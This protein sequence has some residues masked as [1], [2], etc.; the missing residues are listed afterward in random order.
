MVP[1]SLSL[2]YF[3]PFYV[4]IVYLIV[5]DYMLCRPGMNRCDVSEE[6][7][8]NA[9]H[10]LYLAPAPENGAS[11]DGRDVAAPGASLASGVCLGQN[12][13]LHVQNVPI[14][15]KKKSA[16]KDASSIPT[17]S[18][19]SQIPNFVKKDEQAFVKSRSSNDT[20]QY[21]HS[22][23]DSSSK[24]GLG[25]TSRL[26]DFGVEKHKPKQKDKHKNRRGNSDGGTILL[27]ILF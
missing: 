18:T 4:F 17:H 21:L 1:F 24:G 16:L 8:T 5:Y 25:N 15:E 23:I 13:E 9:L 6:E 11:L 27:A 19:P 7:T 2:L 22:E 26:T 10:A 20:N 14:T 3:A 12:L